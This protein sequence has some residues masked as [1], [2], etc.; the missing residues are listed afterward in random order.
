M[1]ER[2][3]LWGEK[4]ALSYRAKPENIDKEFV[5]MKLKKLSTNQSRCGW[6]QN[7]GPVIGYV[8]KS[9]HVRHAHPIM[10]FCSMTVCLI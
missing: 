5:S 7:P 1:Q 2:G 9:D 10:S 6:H 3:D 4:V 8:F